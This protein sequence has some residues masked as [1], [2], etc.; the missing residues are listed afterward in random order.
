MQ[1]FTQP[2]WWSNLATHLRHSRH[3]QGMPAVVVVST[4]QACR[5]PTAAPITTDRPQTLQCLARAGRC[6]PQV[7]HSLRL[8]VTPSYGVRSQCATLALLTKPGSLTLA[9]RNAAKHSA[10][11]PVPVYLLNACCWCERLWLKCEIAADCH[12]AAAP[13]M[14]QAGTPGIGSS[15]NTCSWYILYLHRQHHSV[16]GSRDQRQAAGMSHIK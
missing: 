13:H 4:Q 8:F 9:A 15:A 12:E 5:P 16:R 3:T 11:T 10:S 14:C 7:L 2:Q 1:L 6:R